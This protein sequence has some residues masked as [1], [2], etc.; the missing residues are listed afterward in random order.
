MCCC[1]K[2]TINGTRE[3]K[4]QP[5]DAPSVYPLNPPTP[6]ENETILFDE[7]GRCGGLDGHSH[8]FMLVKDIATHLLVTH[9][10][11]SERIRLS[12][13][14]RLTFDALKTM[15]SNSRFWLFW[16]ILDAH[17][18]GA[19][20]AQEKESAKWRVAAAEKRIKTRKYPARGGVKVWIEAALLVLMLF[21]V[22]LIHAANRKSGPA[23]T[24]KTAIVKAYD[25]SHTIYLMRKTSGQWQAVDTQGNAVS[26]SDAGIVSDAIGLQIELL[27]AS[28]A[29][30]ALHILAKHGSKD[31]TYCAVN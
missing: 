28:T 10:G 21:S 9:G 18:D 1:G 16:T 27:H 7:P 20:E 5:N 8:H 22:P 11:G 23:I 19:R 4:W 6:Q 15:D 12:S 3:F 26:L 29:R 2:P 13:S 14:T 24:A 31:W 17:H 30:E 25:D